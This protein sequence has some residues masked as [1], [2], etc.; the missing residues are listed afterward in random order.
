MNCQAQTDAVILHNTRSMSPAS[1]MQADTHVIANTQFS[2]MPASIY[3]IGNVGRQSTGPIAAFLR[4]LPPAQPEA[5]AKVMAA[6]LA[7]TATANAQQQKHAV[8]AVVQVCVRPEQKTGQGRALPKLQQPFLMCPVDMQIGQLQKVS[9]LFLCTV[10][11]LSVQLRQATCS[12][13][14]YYQSVFFVWHTT[15]ASSLLLAPTAMLSV[16]HAQMASGA[17]TF[18]LLAPSVTAGSV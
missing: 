3:T 8:H 4:P 2:A 18:K 10:I 16:L 7:A 1:C 12:F 14:V 9:K 6:S 5:E 17:R 13:S 11:R 15:C